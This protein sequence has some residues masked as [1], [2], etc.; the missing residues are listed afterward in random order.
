MSP[1]MASPFSKL[2]LLVV[3]AAVLFTPR[4]PPPP[5]RAREGPRASAPSTSPPRSP[6]LGAAPGPGTR[7]V[8]RPRAPHQPVASK[9]GAAGGGSGPL[10][11]KETGCP[12]PQRPGHAR[13]PGQ[14]HHRKLPR[15]RPQ[16][17]EKAGAEVLSGRGGHVSASELHSKGASSPPMSC[18]SG[19]IS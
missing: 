6:R 10:P 14:A 9:G 8:R 7:A 17:P 15:P 16:A 2:L 19:L 11:A 1:A 13:G 4:P 3:A 18:A 12:P 5:S